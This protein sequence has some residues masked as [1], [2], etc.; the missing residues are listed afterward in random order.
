MALFI[1]FSHMVFPHISRTIQCLT[2]CQMIWAFV[3]FGVHWFPA[4]AVEIWTS[5]HNLVIIFLWMRWLLQRRLR[6]T[7]RQPA[8]TTYLTNN[9]FLPEDVESNMS[10]HSILWYAFC[11]QLALILLFICL[12]L[13]ICLAWG[14]G[15]W[16]TRSW[17]LLL[18]LLLQGVLHT[19]V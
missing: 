19:P 13:L 3:S 14:S 1:V 5:W 7:R 2:F 17:W 4:V 9:I 15:G 11:A 8:K 12:F 10:S 6:S 16:G 18:L